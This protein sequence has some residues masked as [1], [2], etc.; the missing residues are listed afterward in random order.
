MDLIVSLQN[1]SKIVKGDIVINCSVGTETS[2]LALSEGMSLGKPA[3]VSN[4][5]GNPYMVK[6]GVNGFIYEC[7]DYRSL[8]KC[9]E[10]LCAD[11]ELYEKMSHESYERFKQELNAENMAQKTNK[12]YDTLYSASRIA[13]QLKLKNARCNRKIYK[14]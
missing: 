13:E 6:H 3:I 10:K 1:R 5:G 2:S 11:V 4:Y 8:A 9:I 7:S 14:Q 12:L